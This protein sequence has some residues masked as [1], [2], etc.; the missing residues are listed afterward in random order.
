MLTILL[1]HLLHR[2]IKHNII[3]SWFN[4]WLFLFVYFDI[5]RR[6]PSQSYVVIKMY[7]LNIYFSIKKK[8]SY[9][10]KTHFKLMSI[11]VIILCFIVWITYVLLMVEFEVIQILF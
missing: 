9:K 6:D 8:Y 3:P 10:Y 11:S 5:N 4:S 7:F 2:Y 1:H